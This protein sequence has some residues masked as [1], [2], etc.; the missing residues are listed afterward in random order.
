MMLLEIPAP[1]M[2]FEVPLDD[3]AR[4]R[5]RRHGNADGVRLFISHGN[6]YAVNGY[7]PYWRHFL[8]R[9]DLVIFDFRNHGENV[10]V[11]PA[12]HTYGQLSRDLERVY[13]DVTAK[14]G[15]RKTAGIFH[16]MSARTAMKHAI[17][18]G[19][20]W[21][22]LVLFD[23]PNV[24]P[25]SHPVYPAMQ[26]FEARLTEFA[27][28]RRTHFAS[29]DELAAEF[30][31]SRV[32]QAWAPGV[33]ELMARAVLRK[34]PNGDGF[35]LVCDP[36]NEAHIYAEAMSLNLW[37]RANDFGGPVKLIG[38]DPDLKG[39]PPTGRANQA[40]G[41]ENGYDYGFVPGTGHMLQLEN[42]DEC[43]RMTLAFLNKCGLA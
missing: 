32:G 7:L 23:P 19:F 10:P 13:R 3:G 37:P 43:A 36:A 6:G 8:S 27:G 24:P 26:V 38:A 15:K 33:H 20:R 1:H 22:A 12:N 4:I 18:I 5:V 17:E 21:D 39:G 25:P 31:K 9:F 14:L 29:V 11:T 2:A 28:K 35:V 41:T 16:S 34:N 40:L 30:A 42:P